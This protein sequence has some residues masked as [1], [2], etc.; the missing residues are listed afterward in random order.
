[1]DKVDFFIVG[2]PKC[3]TTS[4]CEY[5]GEHPQVCFSDAKEPHYFSMDFEGYRTTFSI[6]EYH[7]KEFNH[8]TSSELLRG[9]GSV[10]YLYSRVAIKE[11][12]RYNPYAKIIIMLRNPV[13]MLHSLHSQ[14]LYNLDEDIEDFESAWA[15]QKQRAEGKNLPKKCRV[16][17][18]LQYRDIGSYSIQLERVYNIFPAAQ[19]KI[20]LFDDF[21]TEP[22]RIYTEVLDFLGLEHDGRSNFPVTNQNKTLIFKPLATFIQRPPAIAVALTNRLKKLLNMPRLGIYPLLNQL[23]ILFNSRQQNRTPLRQEFRNILLK[24]FQKDIEK[25]EKIIHRDLSAWK[26]SRIS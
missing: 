22:A 17:E 14:M 11:I 8:C 21:A 13:D 19:V 25:T 10:W 23:N 1:M 12:F 15:A 24:E 2:A 3:G 9:E 7:R 4:L 18:F 16:P 20:I 26:R 6:E 5:L